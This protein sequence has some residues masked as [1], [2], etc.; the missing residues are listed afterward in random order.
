MPDIRSVSSTEIAVCGT[1]AVYFCLGESRNHVSF[2]VVSKLVVPV[3]FGTIYI[4]R[5]LKSTY[6][7]KIQSSLTTPRWYI[8]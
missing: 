8:I 1:I 5:F 4:D 7:A 3:L 2:G 6:A